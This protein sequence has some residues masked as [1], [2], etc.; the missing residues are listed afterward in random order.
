MQMVWFFWTQTCKAC[1]VPLNTQSSETSMRIL[2]REQPGGHTPPIMRTDADI[3][4]PF[5]IKPFNTS[6]LAPSAESLV[7]LSGFMLACC[8]YTLTLRL[9]HATAT[10]DLEVHDYEAAPEEAVGS[11]LLRQSLP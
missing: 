2:T 1:P 6:L 3:I 5:V 9:H 7:E 8:C 10:G 4:L 11:C